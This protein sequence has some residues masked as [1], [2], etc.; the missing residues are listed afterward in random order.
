MIPI[1]GSTHW[2][3]LI[4]DPVE[5]AQTPG[6]MN[7]LIQKKNLDVVLIPLRVKPADLKNTVHALKGIQNFC[8]AIVSMPHKNAVVSMLDVMTAEVHWAGACNIIRRNR[9]GSLAGTLLDG[10]GFVAGLRQHQFE[11]KDRRVLL[12]GAGGAAAGIAFALAKYGVASLHVRNRTASK[13][14][15]LVKKLKLRFPAVNVQ[16]GPYN[17]QDFD[18]VVNATSLGMYEDDMLPLAEKFLQPHMWVADVVVT[19]EMTP[20]L[21]V[22]QKKGCPVH[23]G[24]WM[25][26]TQLEQMLTFMLDQH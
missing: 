3:A 10:E 24:K 4:A 14:E 16:C 9:D 12:L 6:W 21:Q 22:A 13:A 25:L 18:L 23:G 7:D 20:L 8:G 2:M 1:T 17:E 15:L 26:E 19:Q 11:V 5:Q